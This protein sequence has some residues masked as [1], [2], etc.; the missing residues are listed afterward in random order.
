MVKIV[1]S[2]NSD[3]L[4]KVVQ[5]AIQDD[6]ELDENQRRKACHSILVDSAYQIAKRCEEFTYNED[7][8]H[9][10][11][12]TQASK[13]VKHHQNFDIDPKW[14]GF[15][16]DVLRPQIEI[17]ER[18][19]GRPLAKRVEHS[20]E[21]IL[22][23][24]SDL[25]LLINP[26]EGSD[27][28]AEMVRHIAGERKA[29][30]K[31]SAFR[32][33]ACVTLAIVD[34]NDPF[35]PLATAIYNFAN[36]QTYGSVGVVGR[37]GSVTPWAYKGKEESFVRFP[38]LF[39]PQELEVERDLKFFVADYK[40]RFL[41]G[42]TIIRNNLQAYGER[43]GF[44]NIDTPSGVCATAYNCM[45]VIDGSAYNG[46]IDPRAIFQDPP[47][48][49]RHAKLVYTNVIAALPIAQGFGFKVTDYQGNPIENMAQFQLNNKE[50]PRCNPEMTL[51]IARPYF[52]DGKSS[53]D[54]IV[55][56]K[57]AYKPTLQAWDQY[58]AKLK[59]AD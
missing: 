54:V 13:H 35:H 20:G 2:N 45:Q 11:S 36:D 3:H 14:E 29:D 37:D 55:G 28:M 21:R 6:F 48:K 16:N 22:N 53:F 33:A 19:L 7:P 15:A 34:V 25:Y 42:I 24:E 12:L 52:F 38:L 23:A 47:T 49:G 31:P 1:K 27:G 40:F 8:T 17:M 58:K 26:I 4:E 59:E 9:L 50:D 41:D 56:L 51:V 44:E 18:V 5:R 57:E 30:K 10:I 43:Q 39:D 46:Y 32:P